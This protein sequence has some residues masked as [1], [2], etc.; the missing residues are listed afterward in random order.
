M[1]QAEPLGVCEAILN[2]IRTRQDG[3]IAITFEINPKDQDLIS[4]LMRKFAMGE[5]LFTVGVA[6]KVE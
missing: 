5:K 2:S 3:S 6:V 1:K 4:S